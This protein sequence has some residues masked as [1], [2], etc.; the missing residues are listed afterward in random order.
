[1][2]RFTIALVA[3]SLAGSLAAGCAAPGGAGRGEQAAAGEA[4]TIDV[5]KPRKKPAG[6]A[7]DEDYALRVNRTLIVPVRYQRAEELV[8]TLR[9][10]LAARYGP[11]VEVVAHA[12]TNQLLIYL[13]PL[14]ARDGGGVAGTAPGTRTTPVP[15][16]PTTQAPPQGAPASRGPGRRR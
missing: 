9:P 4:S 11:G 15:S 8:E 6:G 5:Y 2:E 16:T 12:S 14:S 7:V 3:A 1:M 10:L 13:P